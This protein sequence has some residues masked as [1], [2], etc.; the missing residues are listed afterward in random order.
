[1]IFQYLNAI[2][3]GINSTTENIIKEIFLNQKSVTNKFELA[4]YSRNK[5]SPQIINTIVEKY[6]LIL[7]Y[8]TGKKNN[9]QII[10]DKINDPLALNAPNSSEFV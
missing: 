4:Q 2:N 9:E 6:F 3:N 5:L 8:T 7:V 10:I 1:M